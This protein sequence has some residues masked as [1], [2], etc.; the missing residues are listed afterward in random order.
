M[1]TFDLGHWALDNDDRLNAAMQ[2]V[3]GKFPTYW[4]SG[5]CEKARDSIIDDL[6]AALADYC[7]AAEDH[8]DANGQWLRG[9][10]AGERAM[11]SA[12]TAVEQI[13]NRYRD[14]RDRAP[15]REG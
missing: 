6:C 7:D 9:Q 3:R 13:V 4:E 11:D 14:L 1:A 8:I 10:Q 5:E 2:I 15:A 12:A